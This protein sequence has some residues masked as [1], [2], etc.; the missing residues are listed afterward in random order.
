[1]Y[2][3]SI[4]EHFIL[5]QDERQSAKVNYPLFYV[6]FGYLYAIMAGSRDWSDIPEY[7][8]EHHEWFLKHNLF[9]NGVPVETPLPA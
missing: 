4:K 3:D 7:V 9:E 8:M 2:I 1:M 5:I 6:L